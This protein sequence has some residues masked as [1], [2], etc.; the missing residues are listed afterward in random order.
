MAQ[1]VSSHAVPCGAVFRIIHVEYY[2]YC[3]HN[4]STGFWHYWKQAVYSNHHYQIPTPNLML[5]YII[6]DELSTGC[7]QMQAEN[8]SSGDLQFSLLK[9]RVSCCFVSLHNPNVVCIGE[10]FS[11]GWDHHS[12]LSSFWELS[13]VTFELITKAWAPLLEGNA[14]SV[15]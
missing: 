11:F 5:G 7:I 13:I 1:W 14:V 9:S 15:N 2:A 10:C 6:K 3:S 12:F 4:I 8:L